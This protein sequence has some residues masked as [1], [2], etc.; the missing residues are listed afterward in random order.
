VTTTRPT[1]CPRCGQ[2][3]SPT[4]GECFFCDPDPD[5]VGAVVVEAAERFGLLLFEAEELLA[6]GHGDR[7][8]VA[9]SKAIKERPDNLTALALYERARRDVLKGRR[10]EKL[11]ARIA[12]GRALF[13]AGR[14]DEAERIVT[15]ALKLLP[16][17]PLAQQLHVMLKERRLAGGTVEAEAERELDGLALAQARRAAQAGRSALASGW[18]RRALV[19]V[20]RGLRLRPNDPELLEVLR[21]IR[22]SDEEIERLTARRRAV[23]SRVRVAQELLSHDRL[24]ESLAILR[25]VLREEPDDERAQAAV[26]E[27]RSVWK[28]RHAPVVAT[29]GPPSSDAAPLA[30]ATAADRHPVAPAPVRPPP[31]PSDTASRRTPLPARAQPETAIP[32]EILLPRTRRAGP[33]L[34]LALAGAG[35]LMALVYVMV[36]GSSPSPPEVPETAAATQP[37]A[38][39]HAPGPLD[40]VVPE[41]RSAIESTLTDYAHALESRD[42]VLLATARPDL[43]EAA[44]SAL[45]SRFEGAINVAIDLRVLDVIAAGA[46][47]SVPVLRTD[48]IVGGGSAETAP[49]E[50]VLRFRRRGEGWSLD[51][52]PR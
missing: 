2:K 31:G 43:S 35:L 45:L 37:S 48:V 9:A 16:D 21:E 19:E 3:V 25:A 34:A 18:Y 1:C 20:R 33:P 42:A 29:V 49:V 15:S 17:H 39:G 10:R 13:A 50:E 6:R 23:L 8:L 5:G 38:R 28:R 44:R 46:G 51:D 41:L 52:G 27:V 40:A 30:P 7:A 24:D 22:R 36:R 12:E 11:E 26:R 14:F 4:V 47:A 32:Q